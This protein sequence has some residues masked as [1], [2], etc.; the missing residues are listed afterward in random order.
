MAYPYKEGDGREDPATQGPRVVRGGGGTRQLSEGRWIPGPLWLRRA[1]STAYA[2]NRWTYRGFRCAMNVEWVAPAAMVYIPPGEFIMG[3]DSGHHDEQPQHTV[4][5]D[6]YYLDRCPVTN[7][8]FQQFMKIT[9]YKPEGDPLQLFS[10]GQEHHAVRGVTWGDAAAYARWAKKRLPTEAEWEKAA[11]GTDGRIYPWGNEWD[12]AKCNV[13]G[14]RFKK[15]A[16]VGSVEGDR[17]PYGCCDMAGAIWEWCADWHDKSYYVEG[18]K[19]NPKGPDRGEFKVVR[20]GGWQG[21]FRDLAR[22]SCR[23]RG[24]PARLRHTGFRCA[25][26]LPIAMLV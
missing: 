12:P 16:A 15:P 10:P 2:P 3:S 21:D 6:G 5:L 4:H 17:S 18:P 20:G 13:R 22:C 25:K 24:T 23:N 14:E 1:Q 9:N 8:Q 7:A 26:D 19:R 11:R